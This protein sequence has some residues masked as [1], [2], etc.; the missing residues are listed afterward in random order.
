MI[1]ILMH[2]TLRIPGYV[3]INKREVMVVA[4]DMRTPTDTL[5]IML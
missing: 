1:P 4:I 2:L 5:P 3:I